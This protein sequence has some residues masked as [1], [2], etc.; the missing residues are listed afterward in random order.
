MRTKHQ[1]IAQELGD[2]V[3]EKNAA[4]G[5]SFDR[6]GEVMLVL[7]PNGLTPEQMADALGVVRVVDKLFR[8]ANKKDAFGESPW[9]DI[10]GYG[11]LGATRDEPGFQYAPVAPVAAKS[12]PAL[13]KA[14]T[15]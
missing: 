3:A 8:I 1:I 5:G 15:R 13:K 4:Y 14:R 11:I 7:Y 6:A 12:G 10:A 2:V 9:R